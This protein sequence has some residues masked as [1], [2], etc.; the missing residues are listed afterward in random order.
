MKRP[1]CCWV[2]GGHTGFVPGG[3]TNEQRYSG[4]KFT[5]RFTPA[6]PACHKTHRRSDDSIGPTG[7]EKE[8]GKGR[9]NVNK[10]QW[11][12]PVAVAEEMTACERLGLC[13]N[14]S[15]RSSL[16]VSPSPLISEPRPATFLHTEPVTHMH[17]RVV[18]GRPTTRG[19]RARAKPRAVREGA[20]A[21]RTTSESRAGD[22]HRRGEEAGVSRA[23]RRILRRR[24]SL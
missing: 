22:K 23:T 12:L 9:G 18:A 7:S 6:R 19:C 17:T 11:K 2:A 13:S 20:G 14:E 3:I 24:V 8:S 16:D 10:A 21:T 15:S 4:N 1:E 5:Q